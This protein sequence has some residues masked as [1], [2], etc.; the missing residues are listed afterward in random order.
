MLNWIEKH[1]NDDNIFIHFLRM[2]YLIAKA[3]AVPT[4]VCFVAGILIPIMGENKHYV[5]ATL[6]A[7]FA[8]GVIMLGEICRKHEKKQYR[9]Q[10]AKKIEMQQIGS[11]FRSFRETIQQ[12]P[13]WKGTIFKTISNAVCVN[14]HDQIQSIL[15][16]E[17]RISV[18]YVFC[19]SKSKKKKLKILARHSPNGNGGKKS[20]P[21]SERQNYFS[22]RNFHEKSRY[23]Y[24]I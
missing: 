1:K 19:S 21:M 17:T 12:S 15:G 20:F 4:V 18:E 2:I 23:T 8:I 9:I 22:Y 16:C 10:I 13:N 5:G 14:I 24:L 7:L 6:F 11:V 3:P